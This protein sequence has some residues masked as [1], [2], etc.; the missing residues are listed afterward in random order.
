MRKVNVR[1]AKT[2]FSR[3]LRRVAAGEEITIVNRGVPVAR[4]VP[5]S[6]EECTRRLGCFRGQMNI[7]DDFDAPLPD[8]ILG[9]FEWKTGAQN[10]KK[11]IVKYIRRSGPKK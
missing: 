3:L 10:K 1:D 5:I 8:D 2:C 4:L 9:A 6:A 11:E 7:P